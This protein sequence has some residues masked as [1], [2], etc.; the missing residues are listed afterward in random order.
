MR[1][2]RRVRSWESLVSER[3]LDFERIKRLI[4]RRAAIRSAAIARGN[5]D[6]IFFILVLK[7]AITVTIK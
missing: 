7:V 1:L 5:R 3:D 2:S 6:S 4:S